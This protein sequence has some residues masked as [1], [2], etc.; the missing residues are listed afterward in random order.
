MFLTSVVTL[1]ALPVPAMVE[2]PNE[3]AALC[4]APAKVAEV[5]CPGVRDGGYNLLSAELRRRPLRY[6]HIQKTGTGFANTIMRL[7]Q[8]AGN[9]TLPPGAAYQR[10]KDGFRYSPKEGMSRYW[11]TCFPAAANSTSI[12]PKYTAMTEHVPLLPCDVHNSAVLTLLR[13]PVSRFVSQYR[14]F[15]EAGWKQGWNPSGDPKVLRSRRPATLRSGLE[16]FEDYLEIYRPGPRNPLPAVAPHAMQPQA[17][18]PESVVTTSAAAG[19]HEA[20]IK[21]NREVE[22][23]PNVAGCQTKMI[24]GAA[25]D[26]GV[27]PTSEQVEHAKRFSRSLHSLV[28]RT[29]SRRAS[30]RPTNSLPQARYSRMRCAMCARPKPHGRRRPRC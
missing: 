15:G 5:P 3:L 14:Y 25:C 12:G 21:L 24:L 17:L 18:E 9:Y 13:E 6:L 27:Y 22:E 8:Q 1:L 19:C 20:K 10:E 4:R 28:S 11:K 16:A 7:G 26:L 30:V 23:K 2:A 29:A